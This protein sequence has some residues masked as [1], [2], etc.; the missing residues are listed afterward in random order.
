MSKI[1]SETK[2]V[3]HENLSKGLKS[4][5]IQ[6]IAI[7]GAIGAGLF[8]GSVYAINLAGPAVILGYIVVGLIMFFVMRAVGEMSVAEPVS[9]GYVSYGARYVHPFLGFMLPWFTVFGVS[10]GAAAEYN[11]LGKYV[12]YWL[13][14]FPIWESALICVVL[15]TMI[16]FITVSLYGEIEFWMSFIKVATIV[17]MIIVGLGMIVFGIG[18]VDGPV[19]FAHLTDN[20]GFFAGGFKGFMQALVLICFAFGGIEA[21]AIAA[22]E[23]VDVKKNVPK[24]VNATFYRIVIFYVGATFVMLCLQPWDKIGT[25]GS[26]FVTVFSAIGI[27]AAA[28]VINFVVITAALSAMNS[29]IYIGSRLIYNLSVRGQAPKS[30]KKVTR[31]GIPYIALTI[32]LLSQ[33]AGV[34]ANAIIPHT[35]FQIFSSLVVTLLVTN[36]LVILISHLKFRRAKIQ[37]G[38]ENRLDFKAPFFPYANYIGIAFFLMIFAL[39]LTL[40]FARPAMIASPAF[41]F[42][43]WVIY[44]FTVGKRETKAIA[45]L[46]S[47]YTNKVFERSEPQ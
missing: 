46:E 4:R 34:I 29:G 14:N 28:A 21:V 19:G 15:I 40:D 42:I 7:G 16:N 18:H 23:A 17:V 37:S 11:A 22:G 30:M 25:S 41:I 20:N 6:M 2:G 32:V 45:D 10:V 27:P 43:L 3:E 39:M 1:V 36:W 47:E 44:K 26:P 13:P 5:H 38:E 9:G 31:R 8:Y 33:G 24:A 12:Q 35:T